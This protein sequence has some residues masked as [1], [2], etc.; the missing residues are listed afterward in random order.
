MDDVIQLRTEDNA[1]ALEEEGEEEEEEEEEEQ[2]EEDEKEGSLLQWKV[3]EEE[4]STHMSRYFRMI[5][6]IGQ[7]KSEYRKVKMG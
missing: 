1:M 3:G 5:D 7:S 4:E 6:A 2:E